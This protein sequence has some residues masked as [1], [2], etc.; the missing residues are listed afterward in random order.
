MQLRGKNFLCVA[1]TITKYNFPET[2]SLIKLAGDLGAKR[3]LAFNFI[4]TGNAENIIE[5]DLTPV[6]RE[7]LLETLY[8]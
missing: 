3:F 1:S 2:K 4:P 5:A 8:Q 6:M 7:E